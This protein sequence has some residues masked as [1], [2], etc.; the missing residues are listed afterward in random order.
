MPN[1]S[2]QY[3]F[4][5]S[6]SACFRDKHL[7][8]DAGIDLNS[9]FAMSDCVLSKAHVHC[10]TSTPLVFLVVAGFLLTLLGTPGCAPQKRQAGLN[11]A[12]FQALMARLADGWSRQNTEQALSC[13]TEDAIYME[14]PDIQL[15]QGHAELRPYFAALN[16]GTLMRFHSLWFDKGRQIGAGEYSFGETNERVA[17][18]GVV[19]VELRN[20]RIAFWREYQQ[21]GPSS[22][23]RFLDRNN[24]Q[25]RWTI[26]NYPPRPIDRKG[27][28]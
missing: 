3:S 11:S 2:A 12:E 10:V 17:D 22:F 26:E 25:W 21:K 19:V 27:N 20:G 28:N 15:Y 5:G 23:D 16:P 1:D 7:A 4:E 6:R 13:F 24:K 18:H 8:A 9:T 14:P